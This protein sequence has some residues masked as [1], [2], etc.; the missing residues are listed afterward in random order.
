MSLDRADRLALEAVDRGAEG[1]LSGRIAAALELPRELGLA[2]LRALA[3]R[4]LV[5]VKQGRPRLTM[6]GL[7]ALAED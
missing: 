2:K 1:D 7:A 6:Q 3:L 4:G 5:V